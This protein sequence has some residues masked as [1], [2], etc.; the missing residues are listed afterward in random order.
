MT[1]L[2]SL[3]AVVLFIASSAAKAQAANDSLPLYTCFEGEVRN[4]P[5][6]D[7][8][9]RSVFI[10]LRGRP[11]SAERPVRPTSG[12]AVVQ[13][14]PGGHAEHRWVSFHDTLLVLT[15]PQQID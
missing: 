3:V 15:R 11:D 7:T 1:R 9:P 5:P 6:R 4:L 2:H 14:P 8:T 10:V 13:T 12:S